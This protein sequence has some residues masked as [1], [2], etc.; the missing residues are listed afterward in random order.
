MNVVKKSDLYPIIHNEGNKSLWEFINSETAKSLLEENDI[1]EYREWINK[2][3]YNHHNQSGFYKNLEDIFT[4]DGKLEF[5]NG[6]EDIG[7]IKFNEQVV[8]VRNAD[9]G[10]SISLNSKNLDKITKEEWKNFEK[11]ISCLDVA[12]NNAKDFHSLIEFDKLNIELK[13][14]DSLKQNKNKI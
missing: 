13:N 8:I 14:K 3:N 10:I 9:M 6:Q 7:A 1:K 11:I 12:F 5:I 4:I 2:I